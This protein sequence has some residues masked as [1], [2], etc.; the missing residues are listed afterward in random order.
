[1]P[2]QRR[3]EMGKRVRKT[4]RPRSNFLSMILAIVIATV[5]ADRVFRTFFLAQDKALIRA[6]KETVRETAVAAFTGLFALLGNSLR[7]VAA[8][9]R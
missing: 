9:R 4:G 6:A 1:M 8:R 3:G 5:V 2:D 7:L